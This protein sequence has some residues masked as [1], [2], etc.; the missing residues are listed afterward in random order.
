MSPQGVKDI[1]ELQKKLKDLGFSYDPEAEQFSCNICVQNPEPARRMYDGRRGI[2]SFDLASYQSD[3][4]LEP[5]KQPRI[6][7]NLKKDLSRHIQRSQIHLDLKEKLLEE[8]KVESQKQS[9]NVKI[10]MNLFNIR[11]NGILHGASYLN[12]EEDV[13]AALMN[14]TDTGDI[15]M[16]VIS[17]ET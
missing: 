17:L 7:I 4:Q 16:G 6:F 12:F 14:G 9:R 13:V 5:G 11:Y 2:F 3:L 15:I 8:E 10:G 1:S